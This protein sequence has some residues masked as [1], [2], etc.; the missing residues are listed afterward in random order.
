M[1][2]RDRAAGAID[3]LSTSHRPDG[4]VSRLLDSAK[5]TG[6]KV[7]RWCILDV[8]ERCPASRSCDG[9]ALWD[10]C[11][12]IAKTTCNGFFSI[13]DAIAAK[14]R[15]SRE[16]WAAEMLCI[17]PTVQKC[18][19]PSFDREVHEKDLPVPN[20]SEAQHSLSIDF[21]FANPLACLWIART[22]EGE[23]AQVY[24]FDEY[25]QEQQ[26]LDVHLQQ[27]EARPWGKMRRVTCDP[28]GG[29]RNDQTAASNIQ[30]LRRAGYTVRSRKSLIVEGLE[31]IRRALR[32]ALGE[33]RLFI[34]AR[35][36][37]L[38]KAMQSYRY[39]EGT[40]SPIK[41]GTHDH[42]IDALRYFFVNSASEQKV[43]ARRY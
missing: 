40:E 22:G 6:T 34:H 14:K 18:V 7:I 42:L 35:C 38:I 3:A 11:Q 8:L 32:P 41:D 9:C 2:G 29:S 36:V 15:T 37:R 4:L 5:I 26:T 19:F 28:A 23:Q 30:L 10:E 20:A 27:I 43:V 13:D 12:G 39:G 21:G 25:V 31:L 17:R 16:T 1:P 24:V 33:P